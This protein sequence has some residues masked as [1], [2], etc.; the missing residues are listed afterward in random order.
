MADEPRD[1]PLHILDIFDKAGFDQIVWQVKAGK[2][3]GPRLNYALRWLG[4]KDRAARQAR[5]RHQRWMFRLAVATALLALI[6]AVEGAVQLALSI[7]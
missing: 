3:S 4:Q 5:L 6:A 1:I 2:L 7:G